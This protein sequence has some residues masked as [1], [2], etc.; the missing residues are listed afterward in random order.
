[1]KL[2]RASREAIK[3]ACLKFHYAKRV[4][5]SQC[6]Y[7]VFNNKGDWCG[8]IIYGSGSTPHIGT[9]YNLFQGEIAELVRMALNGKQESTSKALSISLKLVKKDNPLLKLIVSYADSAQGHIGII[10]QATNWFYHVDSIVLDMINF[11]GKLIHS[12]TFNKHFR[13][14]TDF[15]I[16][17]KNALRTGVAKRIKPVPKHKYLYPLTKTL[18]IF[19]EGIRKEY[20]KSNLAVIV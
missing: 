6:S 15:G 16:K 3:Y 10:Y 5:V 19:C 17:L 8:V 11:K 9:P 1:M 7:S 14:K 12:R 2:E 18:R 20:P 13:N 4:P